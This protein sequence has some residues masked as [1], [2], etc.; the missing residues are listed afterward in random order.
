MDKLEWSDW[1]YGL[2]CNNCGACPI[3]GVVTDEHGGVTHVVM[4]PRCSVRT[5]KY[6]HLADAKIEW[7]FKFSV[8]E[9][10]EVKL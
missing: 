3:A 10:R 2:P 1:K 4:C 6:V 8:Y 7:T 9:Y 5:S